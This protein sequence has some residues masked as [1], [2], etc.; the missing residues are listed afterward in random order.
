MQTTDVIKLRASKP[1]NNSNIKI[2]SYRP[3]QTIL[4]LENAESQLESVGAKSSE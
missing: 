1:Y 4:P 3:K 2:N